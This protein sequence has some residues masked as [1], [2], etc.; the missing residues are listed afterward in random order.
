MNRGFTLLE[1]L[2]VVAIIVILS[3]F[4]IP[5]WDK[6]IEINKYH[7]D[8]IALE[9]SINRAKITA[10]SK[11]TNVGVCIDTITNRILIYDVGFERGNEPCSGNLLFAVKLRS[12]NTQ[13]I[14]N[15]D[16]IFDPRGLN[17]I[18]GENII[19]INNTELNSYYKI[20][21]MMGAQ[22]VEKGIG[23]C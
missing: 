19:C 15:G 20:I 9:H 6:F 2:I 8:I 3:S 17:I 4:A 10:M 22:R 18:G 1:F 11:T 7:N 21:I 12:I 16:I 14:S 13:I 23:S 5:A